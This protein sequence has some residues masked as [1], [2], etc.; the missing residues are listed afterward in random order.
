MNLQ[1]KIDRANIL[2]NEI[3][4]IEAKHEFY[5]DFPISDLIKIIRMHN[6]AFDMTIDLIKKGAWNG[7]AK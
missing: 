1:H 6:I 5:E 7:K 4:R 2:Y 3:N